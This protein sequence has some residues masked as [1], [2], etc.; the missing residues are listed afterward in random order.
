MVFWFCE[1]GGTIFAS[2]ISAV[3]VEPVAVVEH[4]RAAPRCRRSRWRHARD[5]PHGGRV[6][7]LVLFDD[8][9]RLVAGVE[10]F[11][12]AH[13]DALERIAADGP[14]PG[15]AGGFPRERR[16]PVEVQ[17]VA[18]QRADQVGAALFAQP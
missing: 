9:Q 11:H 17:A 15:G 16:E 13:D 18:R 1:V 5:V 10:H 12:A 6:G 2:R 3:A 8:A 7:R 14:E 4:A